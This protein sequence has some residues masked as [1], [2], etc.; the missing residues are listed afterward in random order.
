VEDWRRARLGNSSYDPE[1]NLVYR[2]GN[3]RRTERRR[4]LGDNLAS[5]VIAD[6]DTGKLGTFSSRHD[7]TGTR[8]SPGAG[9]RQRNGRPRKLCSSPTATRS[10]V[11]DRTTGSFCSASR[12]APDVGQGLDDKGRPIRVNT[13]PSAKG[14]SLSCVQGGTNWYSPSHSPV[15]R[16]FNFPTGITRAFT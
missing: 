5:S 14:R 12:R 16:L 9:G 11:P 6:A 13:A 7:A 4:R 10:T 3:R 15:T 1:L 8:S 2:D